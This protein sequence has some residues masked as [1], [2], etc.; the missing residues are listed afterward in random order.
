MSSLFSCAARNAAVDIGGA[1][2]FFIE[3]GV[4][5]VTTLSL[6]VAVVYT[7]PAWKQNSMHARKKYF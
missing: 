3:H 6:Q 4:E 5:R 2:F 7:M 1:R